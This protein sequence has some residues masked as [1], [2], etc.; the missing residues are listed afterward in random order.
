MAYLEAKAARNRALLRALGHMQASDEPV[1]PEGPPNFDGGA[2]E[3]APQP[4]DPVR[5]HNEFLLEVLQAHR[6]GGGEFWPMAPP[7]Q[8]PP[9]ADQEPE[10][11]QGDDWRKGGT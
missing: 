2:R 3:P 10:Q 11:G 1:E 8:S 5:E 4:S 7:A 9:A 6:G